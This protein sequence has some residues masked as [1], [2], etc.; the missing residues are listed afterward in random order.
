MGFFQNTKPYLRL[1]QACQFGR[2][3]YALD[4]ER[5]NEGARP[6]IIKQIE[7]YDDPIPQVILFML[8]PVYLGVLPGT[9]RLEL[10][11]GL[12]QLRIEGVVH[13]DIYDNFMIEYEKAELGGAEQW[14]KDALPDAFPE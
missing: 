9:K 1:T 13:D 6:L 11:D 4:L 5:I 10:Y 8:V 2:E 7:V 3:F 12:L 14:V